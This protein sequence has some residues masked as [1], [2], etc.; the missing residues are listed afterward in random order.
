MSRPES[1]HAKGSGEVGPDTQLFNV[2]QLSEYEK[3]FY[4]AMRCNGYLRVKNGGWRFKP[5]LMVPFVK[6]FE[7]QRVSFFG[8]G[9]NDIL[10]ANIGVDIPR[11]QNAFRQ[12]PVLDAI[13]KYRQFDEDQASR[14]AFLLGGL[15]RHATFDSSSL[16]EIAKSVNFAARMAMLGEKRSADTIVS[17][18]AMYIISGGSLEEDK[19]FERSVYHMGE[20]VA[21]DPIKPQETSDLGLSQVA[22]LR[23]FW[24]KI[25]ETRARPMP[26][27]SEDM[28]VFADFPT[29]GAE[30]HFP[31]DAPTRYPNFWQRLAIL[32]MSQY[33]RGSYIQ[34]SRNDRDVIEVRMNPSLYPITIVNWNHLRLLLPE[35]NQAF[36]TITINRGDFHGDFHWRNTYDTP[37]LGKLQRVGMVCYAAL[38]ENVPHAER[39]EEINFGSVYLGQTVKLQEGKYNFT[40]NWRGGEGLHGQFGIYAG[41]GDNLPHLAYYLSM[42][43]AN[44]DILPNEDLPFFYNEARTLQ[45]ALELL[46]PHE[47]RRIFSVLQG[48]IEDDRRLRAAAQAGRRMMELLNP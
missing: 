26:D 21:E 19:S 17:S 35:L 32:N 5:L 18:M 36:F 10:F 45:G 4:F 13:R 8:P 27:I 43:L 6:E 47:R 44:P 41:F 15:I 46:W 28:A 31:S 38:F 11:L 1:L 48:G 42:V 2:E 34:L 23:G 9:P 40:G 30:F 39:S 33:Q 14:I 12:P 20:A 37:L 29:V 24:D 3:A 25:Q 16:A 7:G 22:R